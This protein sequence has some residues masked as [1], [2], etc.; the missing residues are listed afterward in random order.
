MKLEVDCSWKNGE[1]SAKVLVRFDNKPKSLFNL[2]DQEVER[3]REL[4]DTCL[5][6]GPVGLN[7][8]ENICIK[9]PKSLYACIAYF[10]ALRS[11]EFFDEAQELFH[12]IQKDF[13][14]KIMTKCLE[15]LYLIEEDK[16]KEFFSLF[17]GNEVIKGAFPKR[18]FFHYQE[19]LLFHFAWEVYHSCQKD[20]FQQE[21]HEKMS[22]MIKD[23]ADKIVFGKKAVI[24]S[25]NT[26]V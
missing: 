1:K 24:P 5:L 25:L 10:F 2:T 16:N 22:S 21:K 8:L 11:F 6:D 15:G 23:I 4:E 17:S 19:V 14:G 12:R 20:V 18:L 13:P 7:E 3:I 9:N 26:T